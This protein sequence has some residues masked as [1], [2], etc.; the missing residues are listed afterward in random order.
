MSLIRFKEMFATRVDSVQMPSVILRV[1]SWIATK[2]VRKTENCIHRRSDLVAHVCQ[3]IAFGLVRSF[4]GLLRSTEFRLF[5]L[6]LRHVVEADQHSAMLV[7]CGQHGRAVYQEC[8]M[9]AV[10]TGEVH[11]DVPLCFARYQALGPRSRPVC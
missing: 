5:L 3:E 9:D 10:R 4:R 6:E 2:H 7:V 1:A 11:R 8:L